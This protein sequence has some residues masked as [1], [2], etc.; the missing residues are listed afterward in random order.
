MTGNA[1]TRTLDV[2][3]AIRVEAAV[4]ASADEPGVAASE[5]IPQITKLVAAAR[6][7]V[8]AALPPSFNYQGKKYYLSCCVHM[9]VLEIF[10]SPGAEPP[11]ATTVFGSSDSFG[12]KTA[13]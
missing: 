3:E 7:A 4:L 11:V 12:H 2:H 13:G 10:A 5:K 8:S 6:A 1:K 9:A